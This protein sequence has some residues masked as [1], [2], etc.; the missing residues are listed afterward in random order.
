M[1]DLPKTGRYYRFA[2]DRSDTHEGGVFPRVVPD[3]TV[4]DLLIVETVKIDPDL[5]RD[6]IGRIKLAEM[7]TFRPYATSLAIFSKS[8]WQFATVTRDAE[9]AEERERNK[10]NGNTER[11]PSMVT[12]M[13]GEHPWERHGDYDG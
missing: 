11:V 9:L 4:Q 5:N 3:N 2:K 12:L 8:G 10:L 1:A 6:V 13:K 7:E